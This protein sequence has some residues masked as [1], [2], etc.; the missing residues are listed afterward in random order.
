MRSRCLP[1]RWN[2]VS[3]VQDLAVSR[4]LLHSSVLLWTLED[5]HDCIHSVALPLQRFLL[6]SANASLR[7]QVRV[8]L[9]GWLRKP[10]RSLHGQMQPTRARTATE[11]SSE[12]TR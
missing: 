11:L 9:G 6:C 5:Q 2:S 7:R 10:H 4:A 8:N 3:G 12:E 1:H